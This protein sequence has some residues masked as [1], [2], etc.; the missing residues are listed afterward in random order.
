MRYSNITVPAS[1]NRTLACTLSQRTSLYIK[2]ITPARSKY[3]TCQKIDLASRRATV[4]SSVQASH[5]T[6]TF[7]G[8]ELGELQRI[9]R[10]RVVLFQLYACCAWLTGTVLQILLHR[11]GSLLFFGVSLLWADMPRLICV[12]ERGETISTRLRLSDISWLQLILA[13]ALGH[14]CSEHPFTLFDKSADC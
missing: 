14:V 8:K 10:I 13:L 2:G 1:A 9:W 12:A 7:S 5:R 4:L 6:D 3:A 11:L